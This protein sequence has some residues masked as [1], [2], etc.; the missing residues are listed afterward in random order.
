MQSLLGISRFI[1][2]L[3][4]KVGRSVLWLVLVAVIISTLNA[5]V[6]KAFDFSSNAY[7]EIQWY[8]YAAIFLLA[9]GYTLLRNEH[10]RIDV[11]LH[12]FPKKVQI[13]VDIFGLVL[14]LLPSVSLIIYLSW[15]MFTMAWTS[16]EM[17]EN[18]GGLIRWPVYLLIPIGFALLWMQGIS[19]L[20]KRIAFL[21]GLIEDPTQRAHGKTAEQE[22]AEA[23]RA[24]SEKA[25]QGDRK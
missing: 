25:A 21:Q 8:L 5:I 13:G 14:F 18:A 3:N 4:E 12:M 24:E 7:L 1:D 11:F 15:P 9:S 16:G 2:A 6:R 19:E 22:L 17:S 20:I 10:V 23:I